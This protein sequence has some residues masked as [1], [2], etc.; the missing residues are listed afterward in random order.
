MKHKDIELAKSSG[1]W[2]YVY[3]GPES[4]GS[5]VKGHLGSSEDHWLKMV[6]TCIITYI[7]WLYFNGIL[8]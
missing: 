4:K 5:G 6:E 1:L 8:A 7:F 3:F 2:N